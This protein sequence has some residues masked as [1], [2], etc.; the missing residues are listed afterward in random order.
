MKVS[1]IRFE[2][3][4]H[5]SVRNLFDKEGITDLRQFVGVCHDELKEPY[6]S[7]T[8]DYLI[9]FPIQKVWEAYVFL[10]PNE[11]WDSDIIKFQLLYDRDQDSLVYSNEPFTKMT[12]GQIY[13][14][15]L[16]IVPGFHIPVLH[17]VSQLDEQEK[18]MQTCYLNTGKS[19]GSQW[20]K[21]KES[22]SGGTVV[23]H[24]TRYKGTNI[25]RDRIL[26]P[27][28]HEKAIDR[29]HANAHKSLRR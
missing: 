28:F 15:D 27:I 23:T 20:I 4:S 13:F 26:Y 17:L 25:I 18:V 3:I 2:K 9:D 11:L 14:V 7:H 10:H 19:E 8:K 21:L 6:L 24:E 5:R 29:F 12:V 22:A 16:K 1:E